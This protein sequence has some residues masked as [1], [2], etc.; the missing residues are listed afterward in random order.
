MFPRVRN[1]FSREDQVEAQ[2]V[3]AF[4]GR[5]SWITVAVEI[6]F[7]SR[8]VRVLTIDSLLDENLLWIGNP[9]C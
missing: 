8:L 7:I 5:I 1:E 3:D 9:L 6:H 2:R 4:P